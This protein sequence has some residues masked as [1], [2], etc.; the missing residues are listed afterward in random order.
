[1]LKLLG[2][3]SNGR[4]HRNIRDDCKDG[5]LS[6]RCGLENFGLGFGI[7][8]LTI[9]GKVTQA[10]IQDRWCGIF[11][12]SQSNPF[13]TS[14]III[15]SS[16]GM[17]KRSA[18][19]SKTALKFNAKSLWSSHRPNPLREDVGVRYMRCLDA[20]PVMCLAFETS[21]RPRQPCLSSTRKIRMGRQDSPHLDSATKPPSIFEDTLSI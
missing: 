5:I 17:A 1:M 9:V 19:T 14:Y 11:I 13:S 7:D 12:D 21:P 3:I 16:L 6:S 10:G 20:S 15:H 4:E 2:Q 8:E 18:V